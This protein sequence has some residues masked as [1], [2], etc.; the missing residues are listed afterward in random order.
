[1]QKKLR[2]NKDYLAI[3]PSLSYLDLGEIGRSSNCQTA[4]TAGPSP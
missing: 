1:M 2:A 3:E 4:S